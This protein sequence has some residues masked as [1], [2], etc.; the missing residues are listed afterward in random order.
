VPALAP[1]IAERPQTEDQPTGGSQGRGIIHEPVKNEFGLR[2]DGNF[3][4]IQKFKPRG[5]VIPVEI[6]VPCTEL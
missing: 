6:L 5:A 1:D 3:G 4:S 2:P